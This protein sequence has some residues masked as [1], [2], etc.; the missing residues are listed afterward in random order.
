[1]ADLDFITDLR[2][3]FKISLTDNPQKVSGNRQLLNHFEI[4]FL[5]QAKT[6]LQGE[7]G[8]PLFTEEE[9]ERS[10]FVDNY[11]GNANDLI[12]RPHVLN[13]ASGVVAAMAVAIEKT[14]QSI[15]QD[16]DGLPA[17]EKLASASLL[18]MY[19]ENNIIYAT[20][21]VV[22]VETDSYE[23]LIANLPVVLRP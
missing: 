18:N 14:V 4:T 6:Y 10:V 3:G 1:M 2:E 8:T 9:I 19:I 16:Q 5:T 11:G 22:P 7:V 13:D 17:N 15:L 12:S 21:H 20:V 23:T